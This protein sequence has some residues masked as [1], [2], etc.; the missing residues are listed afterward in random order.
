MAT[1]NKQVLL[2]SVPKGMVKTSDFEVVSTPFDLAAAGNASGELVVQNLFF[3]IDPYMRG[4]MNVGA[5]SYAASWALGEPCRT[6]SVCKVVKSNNPKF[7]VGDHVSGPTGWEEYT[8]TTGEGFNPIKEIPGQPLSIYLGVLGGPGLTAFIGLYKYA[9]PL[10]AGETL[11]VNAAAGAVGTVV[12][13]IGKALGMRVVG[14]AGSDDKVALLKEIGFDEAFNYKTP[15]GGS[16]EAA[17]KQACPNGIDIYFENVGGSHFDTVLPLL[18]EYARV[19]V[20][21]W[22]AEYNTEGKLTPLHNM[23]PVVILKRISIRGFIVSDDIPEYIGQF[24]NEMIPWITSGKIKVIEDVRG[25]IDIA[26]EYFVGMFA[27]GANRGK[28]VV[29]VAP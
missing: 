8:V 11:Y 10:K 19:P 4:R 23:G 22:I 12:G 6:Y 25:P 2:K 20:C 21:G 26:P 14:S 16:L 9:A 5:K 7:A 17:L 29:K 18:N 13:Q 15:P 24:M 28:A 3:S 1:V 27:E